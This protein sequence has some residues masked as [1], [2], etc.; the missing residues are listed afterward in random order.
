MN[1]QTELFRATLGFDFIFSESETGKQI[2]CIEINGADTGLKAVLEIPAGEI[3]EADRAMVAKRMT[4]TKERLEL[5]AIAEALDPVTQ[6]EERKTAWANARSVPGFVHAFINPPF[7]SDIVSKD[8]NAQ[9]QFIPQIYQPKSCQG[10][11]RSST[12]YWIIKPIDGRK[13]RGI[14]IVS[15]DEFKTAFANTDI[16]KTHLVQELIQACGADNAP[17]EM[18]NN[19][20]SLRL[21]M[22]FIYH[23]DDSIEEVFAFAYQR[24][25]TKSLDGDS[26]EDTYI[27]N[28]ARGA[29]AVTASQEEFDMAHAVAVCIIRSLAARIKSTL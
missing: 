27:V 1:E 24:V 12:G 25:S 2:F 6:A 28:Y 3:T 14:S 19:P 26:M 7:I 21:L 5:S 17:Q 20:A 10:N 11:P 22:D 15:N 13:G 18:E 4:H 29:K 9:Q 23:E 8:K 16:R